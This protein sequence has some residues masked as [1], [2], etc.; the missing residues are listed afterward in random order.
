MNLKDLIVQKCQKLFT[1]KKEQTEENF[2]DDVKP[3]PFCGSRSYVYA[4]SGS[5]SSIA[6]YTVHCSNVCCLQ[7][8]VETIEK[9]KENWNKR[10]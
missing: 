6:S 1:K 5:S 9:A 8:S 7:K 3:C 4:A 2:V 10:A